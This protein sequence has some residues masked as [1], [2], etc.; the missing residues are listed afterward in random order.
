MST[1]AIIA[2]APDP[3]T[4]D[5]RG[6]YNHYDGYPTALGRKLHALC[7][8]HFDGDAHALGIY[9][10]REHSGWS[11][12]VAPGEQAP[13]E[14]R[15]CYC[16][17]PQA[18]IAAD[19]DRQRYTPTDLTDPELSIGIEWVYIVEP[20]RL[21]VLAPTERAYKPVGH[22][23]WT[24]QPTDADWTRVECGQDYGRCTHYAWVH[25]DVPEESKR[26]A[27]AKWLGREPLD[28]VRDAI[29]WRLA[30]GTLAR[31]GGHGYA[32]TY[33]GKPRGWYESVTLPD[34]T[35][36]DLRVC[37]GE[38]EHRVRPDLTPVFPPTRETQP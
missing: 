17:G 2:Y 25:F 9:L 33:L 22:V 32:G 30:D 4:R 8:D 7:R 10:T 24:D 37:R 3:E 20:E 12:I 6:V 18:D 29:G 1:R 16:H 35:T 21:I 15:G 5:W 38:R 14:H 34:G 28:P 26:L 13:P 27:T 23:A 36:R 31:R 19:D 11:S